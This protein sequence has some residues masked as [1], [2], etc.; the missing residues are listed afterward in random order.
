MEEE[1]QALPPPLQ[2]PAGYRRD[3][4]TFTFDYANNVYLESSA[5]DLKLIFGQLDQAEGAINVDQHTAITIPWPQAKVLIYF[6]KVHLLAYEIENG[7]IVVPKIALPP[8]PQP[9]SGELKDNPIALRLYEI[10]KSMWQKLVAESSPPPQS[11]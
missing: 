8:E 7:K 3:E 5:W 4:E 2:K 9:P 11:A 1:K 10:I 6:L